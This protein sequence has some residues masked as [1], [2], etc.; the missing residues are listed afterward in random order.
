M[1]L[2]G[3]APRNILIAVASQFLVIINAMIRDKKTPIPLA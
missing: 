1:R 2:K 3:K